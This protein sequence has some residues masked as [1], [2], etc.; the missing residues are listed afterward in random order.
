MRVFQRFKCK[1][2]FK[3]QLCYLLCSLTVADV[4]DVAE[5]AVV[6]DVADDAGYRWQPV[7]KIKRFSLYL[8][9]LQTK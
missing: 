6:A 7:Q 4:V 8:S 2:I 5:V 9:G 1:F 3:T